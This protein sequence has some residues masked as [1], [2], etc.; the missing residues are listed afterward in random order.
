MR[1]LDPQEMA[2]LD[3]LQAVD[4]GP[5]ADAKDAPPGLTKGF[6]GYPKRDGCDY[7]E[8]EM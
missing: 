3:D 8:E 2:F 4:L 7:F 1:D 5:V 6:G